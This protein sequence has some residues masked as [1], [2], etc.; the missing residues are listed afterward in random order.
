MVLFSLCFPREL[1]MIFEVTLMASIMLS[2]LHGKLAKPV[3][4][5][6]ISVSINGDAFATSVSYKPTDSQLSFVFFLPP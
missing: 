1:L 4:F 6:D 5:L 3:S 2:N